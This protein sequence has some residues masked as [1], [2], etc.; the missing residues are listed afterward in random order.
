MR[1][2]GIILSGYPQ[3]FQPS[4]KT[5]VRKAREISNL[6]F[7]STQNIIFRST[8]IIQYEHV[9]SFSRRGQ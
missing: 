6:L 8:E 9:M 4:V 1:L 5:Y 2:T 7:F 3:P